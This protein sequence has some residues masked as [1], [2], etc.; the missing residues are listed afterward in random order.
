MESKRGVGVEAPSCTIA[1]S[2]WVRCALEAMFMCVSVANVRP[3][4]MLERRCWV[5]LPHLVARRA[6]ASQRPVRGSA[7]CLSCPFFYFA[8]INVSVSLFLFLD[9]GKI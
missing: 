4:A 7:R 3:S 2:G 8:A 9:L 5:F 1:L 6:P